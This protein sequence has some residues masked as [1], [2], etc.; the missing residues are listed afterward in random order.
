MRL[1]LGIY[2]AS[3]EGQTEK[4]AEHVA[5]YARDLKFV[6]WSKAISETTQ[7]SNQVPVKV[8]VN[9]INLATASPPQIDQ[10]THDAILMAGP[11][12]GSHLPPTLTSFIKHNLTTLNNPN[13]TTAFIQVSLSAASKGPTGQA[14]A[15]KVLDAFLTKTHFHPTLTASVAGALAYTHYGFFQKRLLY[16]MTSK[17]YEQD[18][19]DLGVPFDKAS[20]PADFER[21]YEYT[22]WETVDHV[23]D[24]LLRSAAERKM[25]EEEGQ[26]EK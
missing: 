17:A 16:W 9:L 18:A 24:D 7:E 5:A 1:A 4:I 22:E 21:D 12:H 8:D 23:V 25:E 19:K 26:K 20:V 11:L 15:Q 13:L 14:N 3:V 6:N 10:T 2:Y